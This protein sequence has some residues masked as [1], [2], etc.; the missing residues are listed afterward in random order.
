MVAFKNLIPQGILFIF[1]KIRIMPYGIVAMHFI[2]K[3]FFHAKSI[4][5][6]IREVSRPMD[7]LCDRTAA[8]AMASIR[9]ASMSSHSSSTSDQSPR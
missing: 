2:Q 1:I 9:P 8:M 5:L 6:K 7:G 3:L 4:F